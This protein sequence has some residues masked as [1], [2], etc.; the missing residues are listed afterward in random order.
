MEEEVP[1]S[2]INWMWSSGPDGS[3]ELVPK[4]GVQR[5]L[6]E[7]MKRLVM[8][9]Q[10]ACEARRGS[11]RGVKMISTARRRI[12]NCRGVGLRQLQRLL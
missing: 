3:G 10:R 8:G 5:G 9:A 6:M 2:Q 1:L 11:R 12:I 4:K 7:G